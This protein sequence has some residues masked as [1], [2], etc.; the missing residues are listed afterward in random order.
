MV[1]HIRLHSPAERLGDSSDGQREDF[2]EEGCHAFKFWIKSTT[3][4][5]IKRNQAAARAVGRAP[6]VQGETSV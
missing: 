3:V 2:K 6:K 1:K 4:L 5:Y